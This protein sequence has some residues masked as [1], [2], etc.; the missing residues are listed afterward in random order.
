MLIIAL[1]PCLCK[2]DEALNR[3]VLV[4]AAS[5]KDCRIDRPASCAPGRLLASC[6]DDHTAKIWTTSRDR[7]LHDLRDHRKEIYTIKWS[8]TGLPG[9]SHS[10][11]RP[12]LA[13]ASF[14]HSF[15]LGLHSCETFCTHFLP[16]AGCYV[17]SALTS[18]C[19]ACKAYCACQ[20]WT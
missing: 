16:H 13:T 4:I 6:S 17:A 9:G 10:G 14:D 20:A 3:R 15:R 11:V 5:F 18:N 1:M 19:Q 12:V 8:P 2:L 7:C